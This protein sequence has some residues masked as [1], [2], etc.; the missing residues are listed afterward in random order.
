MYPWLMLEVGRPRTEVCR[1]LVRNPCA[2][3]VDVDVSAGAWP[4]AD[5]SLCSMA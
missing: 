2:E 4:E 5:V 3:E 1:C